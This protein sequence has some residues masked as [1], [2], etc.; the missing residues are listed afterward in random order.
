VSAE[1]GP[2]NQPARIL[3]V[4]DER[5]NRRLLEA[6]LTPEGF[7]L[8]SAS[9]GEEA[10]SMVAEQPPDLI[11]LDLMMPGMSGYEVAGRI[12]SNAATKNIPVIVV[13]ALNDRGTRLQ[14]FGAG[15][16]AF[17]T[18]PVDRV[19]LCL[20]VRNLLRLKAHG[21]YHDRYSQLLEG[22][23][24]SRAADLAQSERLYRET[25]DAAPV[26]IVHIGLDGL[27]LRV[28]QRLSEL[29][30]FSRE[31]L[32]S[33]AAQELTQPEEVPG[34]AYS[35][36]Q[37]AAG[38]LDRHV[39][40]GKRYRRRDGSFVWARVKTSVHRD[41]EGRCQHFISVIEDI[42][43]RRT[44]EAEIRESVAHLNASE[45]RYRALLD[46]AHDTIAVLTPKG[47]VREVNQR[48]VDLTGLT[49]E[50]IVGR[51][52][53]DFAP[54]GRG[55]ANSQAYG[56][57]L[58]SV[59]RTPVEIAR[60]DGSVALMEFS[61]TIAE[62]A[63][64][65]LVLAIGRDVTAQRALEE[66]LR[67]AQKLE[68]IGQLAGGIAHDFNNLLTAILGFSE[69]VLADLRPADPMLPD[70]LEIKKAGER[71]AGLT[72]QLLAFSRKQILLPSV[73]GINEII[74]GMQP[75]LRR[76]IIEHVELVVSL[77]ERIGSIRIDPSQ[78]EQIVINLAVNAADAMPR[79]GTLTIETANVTLD[80]NVQQYHGAITPGDYVMLAVSDTGIGMDEAT[81]RR[82]FEP[83]FTTKAVG[84]GTGLGLA[85]VYGIVKQSGGDIWVYS[86]PGHGS[87][88]K[89]YLPLVTA[90]A[91]TGARAMVEEKLLQ[92]TET[93]LLVEDEEAVRRLAR[94]ILERGGYRVLEAENPEIALRLANDFEGQIDLLL[95]DVIMP[96]S[97]GAPLALRLA[98]LRPKMRVLYMSGYA[99]EA[100]TRLG[101]VVQG[102]P[103]LQKPFTPHGLG[104]KVR[105]VLDAPRPEPASA[106]ADVNTP[107]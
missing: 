45:A 98:Q 74:V 57:G 76:L 53:S 17:L 26:G 101:V 73:L 58:T 78:F 75:M 90:T 39:I 8:T 35:F 21:D 61:R 24:G 38:K 68:V 93:I 40:D 44:H 63:G 66:Q 25:F 102:A 1:P 85:T 19:E 47:I 70:I 46:G 18:K 95:S 49:R 97:Q 32:Q 34:E 52:V 60:P 5:H 106:A 36:R 48:W 72:R 12:K 20:R 67:Q 51:H 23:V 77:Q 29:L 31:Q 7:S 15:A 54:A 56:L 4:D 22:E 71:A 92:G 64:E 10:L 104:R 105:D 103:F 83:F 13:T 91:I 30:G 42:T 33:P 37:M 82:M 88:F 9:S 96:A 69:L 16:E 84:K 41:A 11:L 81:T 6:M 80:G 2:P 94:V 28:N 3:I 43:E 59:N 87:T 79:G 14:G 99:D 65:K 50:Q 100:I 55:E 86:E 27:W 107:G 62:V 89:I